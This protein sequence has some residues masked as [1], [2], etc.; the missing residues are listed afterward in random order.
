MTY[1]SCSQSEG[2]MLSLLSSSISFFLFFCF[3]N[4]FSEG[5]VGY[6]IGLPSA[7]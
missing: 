1:P 6:S 3:L 5:Y 2:N 4:S 7:I